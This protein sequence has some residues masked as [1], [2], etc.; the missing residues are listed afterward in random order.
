M[1]IT[2]D[3]PPETEVRA[4]KQASKIGENLENYLKTLIDEETARREQIEEVSE[5]SF[6]E[7]LAP[8]HKQFEESGMSEEELD[9]FL[10]ELREEVWQEKQQ[11]K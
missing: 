7:I 4:K 9:E 8:I 3:L 6:R 11:S 5:K 2:I 1:N 10:E